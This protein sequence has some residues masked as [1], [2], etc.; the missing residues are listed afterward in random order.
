MVQLRGWHGAGVETDARG[1][2]VETG[3]STSTVHLDYQCQAHA[4]VLT[5]CFFMN[6]IG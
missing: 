3:L 5:S 6:V 4:G 1:A 2:G